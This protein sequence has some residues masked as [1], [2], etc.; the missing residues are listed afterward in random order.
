MDALWKSI[1]YMSIFSM[2]VAGKI[3]KKKG[4]LKKKTEKK[5]HVY[6]KENGCMF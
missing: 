1:F 5:T 4:P 2:K 6:Q 3:L